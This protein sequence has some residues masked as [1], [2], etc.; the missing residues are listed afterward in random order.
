MR[1]VWWIWFSLQVGFALLGFCFGCGFGVRC[2]W[3][4]LL[5][6]VL[7][8]SGLMR[9]VG[10]VVC[11][12]I[13]VLWIGCFGGLGCFPRFGLGVDLLYVVA[14]SWWMGLCV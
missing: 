6:L 13:W 5:L 8:G 11:C 3:C 10:F 14:R 1:C 4:G 7:V 12:V 9:F 2:V